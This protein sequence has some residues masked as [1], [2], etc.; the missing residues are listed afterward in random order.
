M[1]R[2]IG[3]DIIEIHR[4]EQA[5]KKNPKFLERI[6]TD[7]EIVYIKEN[8]KPVAT[9]AGYFAAKEAVSKALGTGFRGFS[10]KDIEIHKDEKSRPWVFLHRNAKKQLEN[11]GGTE[12]WIS[13]SHSKTDAVAQAVISKGGSKD[14]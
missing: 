2:G 14:E 13:I 7:K 5:L 4:I 1:I 11:M 12:V 6:L 9:L 3:I 10:F 8:D